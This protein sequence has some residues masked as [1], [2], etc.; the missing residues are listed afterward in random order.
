MALGPKTIWPNLLVTPTSLGDLQVQWV[1]N[2]GTNLAFQNMWS[3]KVRIEQ[4]TGALQVAT[5]T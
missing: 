4:T 2:S 5:R 3:V 1:S